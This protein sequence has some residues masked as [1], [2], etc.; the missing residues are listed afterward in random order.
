MTSL[1]CFSVHFL[2]PLRVLSL[3]TVALAS[4]LVTDAAAGVE[5][6]NWPDDHGPPVFAA[7]A[8]DAADEWWTTRAVLRSQALRSPRV[9]VLGG[10]RV[11]GCRYIR[12]RRRRVVPVVVHRV[13]P[14]AARRRGRVVGGG[15][16][17]R[18]G[19]ARSKVRRRRRRRRRRAARARRRG[20]RALA[21]PA[22]GRARPGPGDDGVEGGVFGW[23][24]VERRE[25]RG[26]DQPRNPRVKRV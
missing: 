6:P 22:R 25:R 1:S 19:A 7:A 12:R 23:I 17:D 26:R 24:R 3:D 16:N 21:S 2:A 11:Q 4:C 8:A 15:A 9:R 14:H 5:G 10:R 20:P 18:N 13:A